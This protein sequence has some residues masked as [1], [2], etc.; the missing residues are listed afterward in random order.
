V[1]CTTPTTRTAV[2]SYVDPSGTQTTPAERW[3]GSG[4][5]IQSTPGAAPGGTLLGV[6]CTSATSCVA[7]GMDSTAALT[8][9][10]AG[11]SWSTQRVPGVT[12]G[13]AN[14]VS[15]TSPTACTAVGFFPTATGMSMAASWNGSSWATQTTPVPSSVGLVALNSVSC[16]SP[17][18]CTAVG[19]APG[20]A[21]GEPPVA[22]VWNGTSWSIQTIPLPPGATPVQ[23]NGVSCI[24]ATACILVGSYVLDTSQG[25]Y[26]QILAESWNGADWSIQPTPNPPGYDPAA[27]TIHLNA[28]SCTSATTCTAAGDIDS[29]TAL[30][31]RYS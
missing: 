13:Q 17:A 5:S 6:S 21:G 25:Q 14:G 2:G 10:Y 7:V 11:G 16:T 27:H 4:W 28:V 12:G 1:S 30:A 3:N 31:E 24:S 15:C 8:D 29:F 20:G 18:A 9:V 22:E 19:S 26:G 23:L